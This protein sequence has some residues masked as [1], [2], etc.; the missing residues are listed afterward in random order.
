MKAVV[1]D[2]YTLNPGDLSWDEVAAQV[3]DFALYD[4]TAPDQVAARAGDCEILFT[5]KVEITREIMDACPRLRL[6]GLLATGYNIVDIEEAARRG[7][8]VCNVP[9]YSTPSVAQMTFA[10][11]LEIANG[12]GLHDQSVKAGEWTSCKTFSYWKTPQL[13]LWGKTFGVVGFGSTGQAVAAIARALGMRVLVYTRTRRPEALGEG[14]A[15]CGFE[16]LLSQSDVLSLH[17]PLTPQTQGMIDAAALAQ[18]KE[19]AIL[20]NTA[21]GALCDE[22]A[23]AA[24]LHS[25]KLAGAGFDVAAVEPILADNPL[26]QAPRCFLTPHIAWATR[27]A[28]GRLLAVLADNL[29]AFLAGTP[30]N[31]VNGL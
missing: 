2:G 5:N 3:D 28:R 29:R 7:I 22:G 21:R 4:T 9:S 31:V 12:V 8:Y 11:L 1:L 10:L 18:M 17:C 14:M 19:G 6:I 30:Q 13:E 24:A 25:G 15:F 20:L 26:L 16:Q 27:A 23:V